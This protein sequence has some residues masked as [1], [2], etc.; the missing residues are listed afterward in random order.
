MAKFGGI[1]SNAEQAV[2]AATVETIIQIVAPTNHRVA[3]K[4]WGVFF[5]GVS[6]TAEPV[7]VEL[8]RQSTAGTSSANIPVKKDDSIAETLQTT[9]RDAFTAEPTTGDIL[10]RREVHPQQGWYEYFQ[11]GDE[12]ICGGADRIGIRV[13]APAA[14]NAIGEIDFEE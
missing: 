13:T 7:L 4:G 5:D 12:V 11:L 10:K 9:A 14:V 8:V 1:A 3:I 2:A 6:V